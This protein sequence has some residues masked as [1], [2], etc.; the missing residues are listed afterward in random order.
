MRIGNGRV[1]ALVSALALAPTAEAR[2]SIGAP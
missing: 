1:A 2:A